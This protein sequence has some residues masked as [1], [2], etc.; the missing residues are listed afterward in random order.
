GR[1]PL[2]L[3]VLRFTAPLRFGAVF[4]GSGRRRGAGRVRAGAC[5]GEAHCLLELLE[6]D[7]AAFEVGLHE[8]GDLPEEAGAA[9][10]AFDLAAD[11]A[12]KGVAALRGDVQ[13]AGQDARQHLLHAL[14]GQ[15]R[16]LDD[17]KEA[18]G[19]IEGDVDLVRGAA[20]GL[21]DEGEV[22]DPAAVRGLPD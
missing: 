22:G 21:V 16:L 10:A 1:A 7:G 5:N 6:G 13:D 18:Q 17:G 19:V 14:A 3:Y 8:A 2:R 12:K 4:L 11:L 9:D 15:L 20:G